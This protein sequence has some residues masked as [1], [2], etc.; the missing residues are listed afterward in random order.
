M[1]VCDKMTKLLAATIAS[2]LA[3]T[4][5]IVAAPL[6][7]KPA[8][9]A[10][11]R[12]AA[13]AAVKWDLRLT[14]NA[15]GNHLLGNPAAQ[16]K[17]VEFISYTCPHCAHY[18]HD[19]QGSLFPG[20]VRQ[21]KVSVEVRP[22]FRNI[23][24]V[25]AT[26]LAQCGADS[27]FSGNHHAILAAQPQWLKSPPEAVQQRWSTLEF[28]PRMKAVAQDMGLYQLML[29]R[30]YTAAQLDQCLANRPL[31]DRLAKQTD[32]AAERLGV[33]GTPSFLINGK[34]QEVYDWHGLEPL[35]GAA[36]R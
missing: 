33:Q 1:K 32:D 5:L 13:T 25:P 11:P 3:A 31:A 18:A 34:L 2:T 35:L 36:L 10:K 9:S 28:A 23:V 7:A 29:G 22:F 21:G 24:D 26:L 27:R 30:G 12:A 6:T 15:A 14:R 16:I 17:L 19:A 8:A 20:L 4:A